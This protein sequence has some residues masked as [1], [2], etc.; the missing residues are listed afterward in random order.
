MAG[1]ARVIHWFRTDLRLHDSPSL[2]QAL[3]LKPEYL[4]PLFCFDPHYVYEQR[5]GVNRFQFLLDSL[6]ELSDNINRVNCKSQ[7]FV[8]RGPPVTLLPDLMKKWN[9]TH[10]VYEKDE[11]ANLP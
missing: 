6:Q 7:L 4:Y 1:K 8:V 9:I 5:V 10:L 3:A 2:A 11:C